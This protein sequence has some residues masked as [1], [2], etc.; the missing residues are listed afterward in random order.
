MSTTERQTNIV[1]LCTGHESQ[2][3]PRISK[4]FVSVVD[5]A[6]IFQAAKWNL[7]DV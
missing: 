3:D 6:L 1:W 5:F 4:D 2:R 7:T